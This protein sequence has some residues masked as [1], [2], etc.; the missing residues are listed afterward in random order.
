MFPLGLKWI[1][2]RKWEPRFSLFG[3]KKLKY[4]EKG[5]ARMKHHNALELRCIRMNSWFTEYEILL[6]ISLCI[7][8]GWYINTC[9][10]WKDLGIMAIAVST[11]R[12]QIL[13]S[14]HHFQKPGLFEQ[15]LIPGLGQEQY[16]WTNLWSQIMSKKWWDMPKGHRNQLEGIPNSQN[17]FQP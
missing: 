1:H 10:C 11:L 6:C 8:M 13:V 17:N 14:K 16:I 7:S 9:L 5:K 3:K 15:W 4:K 12:A 2:C